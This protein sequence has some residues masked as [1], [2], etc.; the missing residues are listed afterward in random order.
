MRFYE[1]LCL[2]WILFYDVRKDVR[3]SEKVNEM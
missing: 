2:K 1:I 3:I